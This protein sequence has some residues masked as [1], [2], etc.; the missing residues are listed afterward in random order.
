MAGATAA[1]AAA[2]ASLLLGVLSFVVG[3]SPLIGLAVGG[4]SLLLGMWSISATKKHKGL[5]LGYAVAGSGVSLVAIVVG[6]VLL[7]R[8]V[9]N[10]ERPT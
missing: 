4:M 2:I 5:G 10:G 3:Y 9:A 8:A 7:L 1:T 6:V